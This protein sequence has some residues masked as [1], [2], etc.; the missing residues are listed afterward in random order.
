MHMS[1]LYKLIEKDHQ[2]AW[3]DECNKAFF[4]YK[5]MLT[6]DAVLVHYDS[7]KPLI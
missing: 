2:W 7:A 1:L 3:T 6:S 4:K 5:K